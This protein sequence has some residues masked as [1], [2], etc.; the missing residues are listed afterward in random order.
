M[1]SKILLFIS[2]SF[3]VKSIAHPTTQTE[4]KNKYTLACLTPSDINEHVYVL[5]SLAKECGSVTEIGLR[6]MASSWGLL[7]GLSENTLPSRSYL[8]IDLEIPPLEILNEAKYLAKG[9]GISFEFWH[10]NDMDVEIEQTDLL[11]IDSLH[12]YCHLMYELEKFSSKVSKYIVMHDTNLEDLDCTAYCGNYSEYPPEYSRSKKGLWPAVVDFLHDH[13]EWALYDRRMNNY[14][15]TILKRAE[16][17]PF[18]PRAKLSL[19]EVYQEVTRRNLTMVTKERFETI[20]RLSAIIQ[21]EN[22]EGDIVE[23]GVW[24]GGMSIYLAYAFPQKKCWVADSFQGFEP[25]SQC[26]YNPMGIV[27]ERH[28]DGI[29]IESEFDVRQNFANMGL[30]SSNGIEFL[31]GWVN[32]TTDP[33]HCSIEKIA[34]LR[35]D[36]DA[37]SAT[38][39]VLENLFDKVVPGGFIIFDD[40]GLYETDTAIRT[41]EK[42]RGI[43]IISN[44][45]SPQGKHVGRLTGEHGLYYRK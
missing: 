15:L 39:V 30:N 37:Y 9:N 26:K 42:N 32:T 19:S 13:P 31:P 2:L 28:H 17:L 5:R 8:G 21:T 4:L 43:E 6:S 24:R 10:A 12:T 20:D 3:A 1:T 27:E 40:T 44:L 7:L 16:N 25:L 14:G 11:F 33:K 45:Y 22:L 41:F 36:V 38:L 35:I 23:C 18:T 34:L 29:W